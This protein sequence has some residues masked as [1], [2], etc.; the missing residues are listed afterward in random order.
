MTTWMTP[1]KDYFIEE[2]IIST[3]GVFNYSPDK[4]IEVLPNIY[5]P[6][7]M[8]LKLLISSSKNRKKI[9]NLLA[10]KIKKSGCNYICGIE[11]GGSYYASAIADKLDLPLILLRK[12]TKDHGDFQTIVGEKP[13]QKC[14]VCIIDDV[15]ATGLSLNRAKN[16]LSQYGSI[17]QAVVIFSYGYEKPIGRKIGIPIDAL[18]DFNTL[19]KKLSLTKT[20]SSS[21]ILSLKKYLKRYKNFQ[22]PKNSL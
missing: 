21:E 3:A 18:T 9:V 1:N 13:N 19:S 2:K 16:I 4:L 8:N 12:Q 14:R 15:L 22:L 20:L 7:F 6:V 11:S 5:S 17:C 10:T